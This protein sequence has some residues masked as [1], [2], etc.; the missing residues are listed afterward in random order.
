MATF[1]GFPGTAC[2]RVV[3][4]RVRTRVGSDPHTSPILNPFLTSGPPQSSLRHL[5]LR[6][7][8]AAVP[9]AVAVTP[10]GDPA[11]RLGALTHGVHRRW[12]VRFFD[13]LCVRHPNEDRRGSVCRTSL[14]GDPDSV[15]PTNDGVSF[16][17]AQLTLRDNL[18]GV[19]GTG[20][21]RF[22]GT[23]GFPPTRFP[24]DPITDRVRRHPGAIHR[25]LT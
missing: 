8:G 14:G 3:T 24:V 13:P 10:P 17:Q 21:E 1:T 23:T 15:P 2:N 11:A 4:L 5:R 25:E 6:C 12:P 22:P 16:K 18:Q 20:A 19:S 7:P 9:V